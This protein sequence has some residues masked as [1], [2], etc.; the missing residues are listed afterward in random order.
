[1]NIGNICYNGEAC[2]K[3]VLYGSVRIIYAS[4]H[5]DCQNDGVCYFVCKKII[6][7]PSERSV[8]S[9]L[10]VQVFLPCS[11]VN[12]F[13]MEMNASILSDFIAIFLVSCGI[14]VLCSFIANF[15]YRKVETEKRKILQYATVCS[16]AGFL[17]NAV[18]CYIIK[19]RIMRILI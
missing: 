18:K 5:D 7:Q 17:G 2:L 12:A 16:N 11:I 14:Q 1:M 4:I 3:E 13:Q 9:K 8:L 6:L 10:V 19:I 15:G